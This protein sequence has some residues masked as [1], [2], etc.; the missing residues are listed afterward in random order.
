MSQF[1]KLCLVVF[2]GI[3]INFILTLPQFIAFFTMDIDTGHYYGF[4]YPFWLNVIIALGSGQL[5]NYLVKKY[6]K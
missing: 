1:D 6:F 5:S 2:F 3:G 4:A